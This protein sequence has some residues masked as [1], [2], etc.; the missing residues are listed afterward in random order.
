MVAKKKL[1]SNLDSFNNDNELKR[2]CSEQTAKID[3]L[4]DTN[5]KLKNKNTR[6]IREKGFQTKL[7]K[8]LSRKLEKANQQLTRKST[9][10]KSR[11]SERRTRTLLKLKSFKR[12]GV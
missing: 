12:R 6:L 8:S 5:A 7:I 1:S 10:R 11:Q 4:V 3:V 2:L 9:R